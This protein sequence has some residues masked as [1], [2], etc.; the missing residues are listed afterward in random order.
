MPRSPAHPPPAASEHPSVVIHWREPGCA[1]RRLVFPFRP[2]LEWMAVGAATDC[3]VIVTEANFPELGFQINWRPPRPPAL[4]AHPSVVLRDETFS[5]ATLLNSVFPLDDWLAVRL[6]HTA[7]L[8]LVAVAR[9]EPLVPDVIES[10]FERLRR[11]PP[12]RPSD[13]R[14]GCSLAGE[15]T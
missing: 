3:D 6:K 2:G 11:A 5:E 7:T 10:I 13:L 14:L 9:S 15:R 8:F 4:Y 1:D 12:E